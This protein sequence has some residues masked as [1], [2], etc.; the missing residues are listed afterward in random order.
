M[1]KDIKTTQRKRKGSK[2]ARRRR[3]RILFTIEAVVLVVLLAVLGINIWMENRLD[4]SVDFDEDDI[5]INDEIKNSDSNKTGYT[6]V[7]LF[8]V[9]SRDTGSFD[10]GTH[11]DAILVASINNDTGDVKIVSVYRDTYLNNGDDV[12]NKATQAYFSGGPKQAISML[13]MNLDLNITEYV[14]VDFSAITKTVDALGGIEIDVQEDELEHLNNYT[15][16]TSE[17]TG[18]ETTK[19]T[20]AGLQTLDG[21]QATSYARIR[22]TSGDDYKRTERQRTVIEK[23]VEKA[24]A[25]DIATLTKI[26]NEVMP[27]ISTNITL[28]DVLGLLSNI[29]NYNIADTSG[30]PFEKTS[31]SA[32]KSVG[33]IVVPVDLVTN[34]EELHEFLFDDTDYTPSNTVQAI[35]KKISNDTGYT[36]ED[37]EDYTSSSEE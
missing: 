20:H 19:L 11:S 37:R 35:S 24:K 6:N 14:S 29:A 28:T 31:T 13:N 27:E 22:Y 21:V 18:V 7:A 25:S 23:I 10:A 30:F 3:R 16:E 32:I 1:A 5:V 36:E 4:D 2:T 9:D 33:S 26:A 15:V 8:G 12:Y 17:V 34:V